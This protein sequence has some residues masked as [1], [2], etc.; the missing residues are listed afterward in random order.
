MRRLATSM[1]SLTATA[2]LL[3]APGAWAAD[4]RTAEYHAT[5]LAGHPDTTVGTVL[6][7]TFSRERGAREVHHVVGA[8]P[9]TT[10]Q[11]M[12]A[13]A[14]APDC[15]G[16]TVT[17]PGGTL[18]TDDRGNGLTTVVVG[19]GSLATAP[20]TFWVT[21]SLRVDGAIAFVSD[22]LRIDL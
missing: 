16:P 6:D 8:A 1:T 19:P 11:L 7:V 22:C 14:F 15:L 21:W 12:A 10:Y 3:L 4:A 18:D 20:D 5:G 17:V 13:V 2:L 9:S